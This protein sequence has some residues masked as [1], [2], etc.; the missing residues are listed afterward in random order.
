MDKT[1]ID[2]VEPVMDWLAQNYHPHMRIIIDAEN[3]VMSEGVHGFYKLD[4]WL[5]NNKK[6]EQQ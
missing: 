3:A 5:E 2:V 6:E 1:F 4:N